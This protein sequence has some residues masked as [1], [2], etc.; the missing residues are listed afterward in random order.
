[1]ETVLFEG[2]VRDAWK[3]EHTYP[4]SEVVELEYKLPP[5]EHCDVYDVDFNEET[6]QVEKSFREIVDT[7]WLHI[8]LPTYCGLKL[9]DKIKIVKE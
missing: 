2:T 7:G 9:G 1:M 4:H 3:C 5:E 6:G 8:D